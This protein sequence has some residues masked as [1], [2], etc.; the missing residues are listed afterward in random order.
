MS[1]GIK[2]GR[3]I[4]EIGASDFF[5]AFFSTVSGNLEAHGWGTRFP[6]VMRKIYEGEI[7]SLDADV[8][9]S[10]LDQISQELSNLPVSA[11]I[12]DIDDRS[13]PPPWGK[14]IAADITNMSNYF[15]TS[16]GR[17]LIFTLKEA[18]EELR[19]RGGAARIVHY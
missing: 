14:N 3:V 7:G 19:D 10:E 5:H 15:D 1:V 6:V 8:A 13:K 2:V 18:L 11:I 9:L 16:T 17:D 12:W 4:S